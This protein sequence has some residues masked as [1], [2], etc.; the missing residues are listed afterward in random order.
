MSATMSDPEIAN[1]SEAVMD[2][3]YPALLECF[4][5][6]ICG[7]LAGRL[8]IISQTETKGLNTF[9]GTFSLPALIFLSMAQL[10]L[11]AVNWMFL[12]SVLVAKSIV[13]FAVAVIT[14]L[15]GRPTN[16]GRAGL[17]AIFCTQSNDFAIGYPIVS[18]LYSKSHPE[19]SG[20]LYLV[21]PVS[22]VVLNPLGFIMMEIDKRKKHLERIRES[23][24]S[25]PAET[26]GTARVAAAVARSIAFNPVVFMTA[27]GIIGNLIFSHNPPSYVAGIL[28]VLGSA[29]SGTA[30]FLLG[31]RMVGKVHTLKGAAL[32]IPGVLIAVKLL[33]LPLVTR[34]VVSILHAGVN[35]TD[36]LDLSTYGFLY[37]TFPAAPGVFVFSTQYALDVDLI[38]S[39]MVACTFISAPLMFVSA[40]MITINKMNPDDYASELEFFTF[41]V[42][43][44]GLL[45]AIWVL[46]VFVLS[47]KYRRIPHKITSCLVISQL[48]L[49]IGVVV[50]W[51]LPISNDGSKSHHLGTAIQFALVALGS[52]SSRLWTA[53][54]AVTLLL[55]QC[56][57]LCFVLKLQPVFLFLGWGVPAVVVAILLIA[58]N[59]VVAPDMHRLD[60]NFL[61]GE[62]Q[63]IVSVFFLISSFVVTVGCLVLHQRYKRRYARYLSLAQEVSGNV[64]GQSGST[65]EDRRSPMFRRSVN[66]DPAFSGSENGNANQNR[67][68]DIEDLGGGSAKAFRRILSGENGRDGEIGSSGNQDRQD[69]CSSHFGCPQDRREH[70]RQLVARH[71]RLSTCAEEDEEE[72]IDDDEML[73]DVSEVLEDSRNFPEPISSVNIVSSD[74]SDIAQ[75]LRHVV[76]LILLS[77]SM[78]VG[79]SVSIW[80]LVMEQTSGIYV[81]LTFLDASLNFGQSIF[82]F[83]AFGLDSH[84]IVSPF[85][86]RWHKWWYGEEAPIQK[87][88]SELSEETKEVCLRFFR[89]HLANCRRDIK[90]QRRTS[91]T[92]SVVSVGGVGDRSE[93]GCGKFK[94]CDLVAWLLE[95]GLVHDR[96]EGTRYG[97]HLLDGGVI[98]HVAGRHHFHDRSYIYHF[99]CTSSPYLQSDCDSHHES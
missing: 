25:T 76:V 38:A 44:V 40:K 57:S 30:L 16:L 43:V 50:W 70:C 7:Y 34:E 72:L 73:D 92:S 82:V 36:T 89:H 93:V 5:I 47:K 90:K 99:T 91:G 41:D 69:I 2:N 84:I 75:T 28:K 18:A 20:Y 83:A 60:P 14:L 24:N 29:F 87:D 19:Y 32:L 55:L 80:T 13:F 15:V 71:H 9:V 23:G 78:F 64:D 42:A 21:A 94:G 45:F 66:A 65:P 54:L 52:Y 98:R 61:F 26:Y 68:V 49:C 6:I 79:L 97:N 3:L 85:L 58:G 22:L 27:L 67:V 81:E 10:D 39:S 53:F 33:A 74:E 77:C 51:S 59:P 95:V 88:W 1:S 96:A 63:A 86:K 48:L 35:A 4:A 8:N 56:R 46:A 37:G 31:L 17:F 12:L 62:A 11:S